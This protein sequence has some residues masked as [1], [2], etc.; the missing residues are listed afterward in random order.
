M[1]L[2]MLHLRPGGTEVTHRADGGGETGSG[3]EFASEFS[4][5]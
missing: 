3:I 4:Q 5:E 2:G 1:K